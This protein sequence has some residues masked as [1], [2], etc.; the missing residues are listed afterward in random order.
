VNNALLYIGLALVLALGALFSAPLFVD[1]NR[2]RDFVEAEASRL[3]GHEVRIGGPIDVRILPLPT[4]RFERVRVTSKDPIASEPL[5]RAESFTAWL[6]VGALLKGALEA[7]HIELSKPIVHVR[8]DGEG[9]GNWQMLTNRSA[10]GSRRFVS[11]V[12]LQ[13]MTV[14]NGTIVL[15]GSDGRERARIEAI[16][17]EISTPALEGPYR[18]RS[19]FRWHGSD[20]ELRLSTAAPEADGRVR[21]KATI[22]VPA[23]G[24]SWAFDA[25]AVDPLG[26]PRLEGDLTAK[27]PLQG[28][29]KVGQSFELRSR[30]I[31]SPLGFTLEDMNVSFDQESRPQVLTG[32]LKSDWRGTATTQ[33]NVSARWLD[34]D[35]I[36]AGKG[37]SGATG[38]LQALVERLAEVFAG[39]GAGSGELF[40]E[41][42]TIA[43]EVVSSLSVRV[44]RAAGSLMLDKLEAGLPGN[45][46]IEVSGRF[47]GEGTLN[48]D[49]NVILRG[50]SL[51]RFLSWGA[52]GSSLPDGLGDGPFLLRS[53]VGISGPS[54]R[55]DEARAEVAGASL[56]GNIRWD[57]GERH[58]LDLDV[59]V[60]SL[61][62]GGRRD[63]DLSFMRLLD[64]T[65]M[66]AALDTRARIYVG[67]LAFAD[68]RL[69]DIAL[70]ATLK[71]GRLDL[72]SFRVEGDGGLKIAASGDVR[73]I[74][75]QEKGRIGFEIAGDTAAAGEMLAHLLG[76]TSLSDLV[77][78]A[79]PARLQLLP[80]SV[81]GVA[82]IGESRKG[83][84]DLQVDGLAGRSRMEI[85]ANANGHPENWT[86]AAT[87]LRGQINGPAAILLVRDIVGTNRA[88]TASASSTLAFKASG[89]GGDQVD[90]RVTLTSDA[91]NLSYS[92][93]IAT[94]SDGLTWDGVVEVDSKDAAAL[95]A[96]VGLGSVDT[97]RLPVTGRINVV[98]RKDRLRI[99]PIALDA[100]GSRIDG[101]VEFVG[102]AGQRRMAGA[103]HATR[104]TAYA[105]FESLVS[106]RA[107]QSA[108]D[109]GS[110]VLPDRLF[111]L[112]R[113]DGVSGKLALTVDRLALG[114][115]VGLA[116]VTTTVSIGDGAIALEDIRGIA[117]AAP[118]SG[119]VR[120]AQQAGEVAGEGS[121]SIK[122]AD[123]AQILG[124][125]ASGLVTGHADI[126]LS[127]K[128]RAASPRGLVG[129]LSGQ[130]SMDIGTLSIAGLGTERVQS[131]LGERLRPARARDARI[132]EPP[133]QEFAPD[134]LARV[135]QARLSVPAR[136]IDVT[137]GDGA[138]KLQPVLLDLAEAKLTS[139]STIDLG[140]L[141][142]DS[143]WRYELRQQGPRPKSANAALLPAA[144]VVFGGALGDWES[145]TTSVDTAALER[146]LTVIRM[147]REVEELERLRRL[148]EERQREFERMRAQERIE[149]ERRR[150]EAE[151]QQ[152]GVPPVS[153]EGSNGQT[154]SSTAPASNPL[155]PQ[156]WTPATQAGT[157]ESIGATQAQGPGASPGQ[158]IEIKRRP[159]PAPKP[160]PRPQTVY[161]KLFGPVN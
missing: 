126:A 104:L 157:A 91:G 136:R 1:W 56:A 45:S 158:P 109:G 15:A 88:A 14:S 114:E 144:A 75:G 9:G 132:P 22:T 71:G 52:R 41:Q 81:A 67:K 33:A 24:S 66:L 32:S 3:V 142:F 74:G 48:L 131:F 119:R 39:D 107:L 98:S 134:F 153:A 139:I 62:I 21:V 51:Q 130:G 28:A 86:Q 154:T 26:R 16:V 151:A 17:G 6:S 76:G 55:L 4:M 53:R 128:G 143:E 54:L 47:T 84:I 43:G 124:D 2:Y 133:R 147:E 146:E 13:A 99:E 122:G 85:F 140:S 117:M 105:M 64:A 138:I 73:D 18:V 156:A 30:F 38:A 19:N 57:H 115:K 127:F 83:G 42:A 8:H 44:S 161:E 34:L 112:S 113:L 125:T 79:D 65:S 25:F 50:A 27:M 141:R 155:A 90:A 61:D 59:E 95:I 108:D 69:R 89:A 31:G 20:R 11:N 159:P 29:S 36:D 120:L 116:S 100:G 121:L 70:D 94:A 68:K 152:P 49:G 118:L 97:G 87:N 103:L 60:Q 129:N 46:R 150:Q 137:F 12:A 101:S 149:M 160:A 106:R 35:K 102:Q 93:K 5:M 7:T 92:G 148:D 10:P 110:G 135:Q 111:E 63:T 72:R 82:V 77:E 23:S 58:S 96:S 37:R 40:V 78:S 80:L 123:L 145:V